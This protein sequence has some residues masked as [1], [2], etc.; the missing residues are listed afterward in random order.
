MSVYNLKLFIK[1]YLVALILPFETDYERVNTL[2]PCIC[3]DRRVY[4]S[5][6]ELEFL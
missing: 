3:D 1:C 5:E 2:L 4:C 6:D